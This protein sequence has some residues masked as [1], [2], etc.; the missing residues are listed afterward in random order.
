MTSPARPGETKIGKAKVSH[1]RQNQG[2][3]WLPGLT[4]V[5]KVAFLSV[6]NAETRAHRHF[7]SA[8]QEGEWFAVSVEEALA[9]LK[10][11][12]AAEQPARAA[13]L[14]QM[15]LALELGLFEEVGK[16]SNN[17]PNP[18]LEAILNW[19]LPRSSATTAVALAAA[20]SGT[21]GVQ[22]HCGLLNNSGFFTLL[23]DEMAAFNFSEDSALTRH[24]DKRFGKGCWEHQV[25][26]YAGLSKTG[27][28]VKITEWLKHT[29][30]SLKTIDWVKTR[31]Q[32]NRFQTA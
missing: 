19:K 13:F 31:G 21:S 7:S 15:N 10:E 30:A 32:S 29:S 23:C 11:L 4:V 24:L 22:S 26:D 6:F 17:A 27:L 28:P 9:F 2:K 25:Q 16:V 1:K 20:L 3:T 18:V 12:K 14:E 5:E 8:R